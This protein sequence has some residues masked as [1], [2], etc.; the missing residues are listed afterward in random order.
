MRSLTESRRLLQEARDEIQQNRERSQL[1]PTHT[2]SPLP[3][4]FPRPAEVSAIERTLE[5]PPSFTVLFGA[6]S[7]GK[8]AL[9]REVL[10]RDIYHV[11]H[12]DLR[13]AGFADLGSLYASL[14]RQMELYFESMSKIM[15][16][17]EDFEKEAWAFKVCRIHYVIP[18]A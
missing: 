10:S 11:L 18:D 8:T 13:I 17:Y 7:V 5:G 9:L 15:E 6:S 2:F 3:N 12:F 14:S 4:L 16:G 1:R